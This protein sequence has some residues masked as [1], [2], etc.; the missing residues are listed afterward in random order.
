MALN[1]DEIAA[2]LMAM[3]EDQQRDIIKMAHAATADEFP[4]GWYPN[5]G[6]QT[7][8]YYCDADELFYGGEAGGGKT[9]LLLAT[10]LHAHT[11]SLIVRRLNGEVQGLIERMAEILGNRRGLKASSPAHWRVKH[12][13]IKFGG[14]QHD[15]DWEKY[16]G[17]PKDFL[18]FDEITH[19]SEHIFR[20]LIAWNRTVTKGQRSRVIATG[21]PPQSVE[22]MWVIKYWGPWLDKNHPD[23]AVPGEL[24]WYTTIN[25]QDVDVGGYRPDGGPRVRDNPGEIVLGDGTIHRDKNGRPI[26]PKSR[27]FIRAELA[28]N[29]DLAD[30]G[31]G[32][33]LMALPEGLRAG[34]GEGDFGAALKDDLW[35]V[36]PTEW[37]DAAMSRWSPGGGQTKG[38]MDAM[39]VDIAQGGEDKTVISRRHGGWYD[40][41]L[42]W[43]GKD[44]PDGPSVGA[45]V[46]LNRRDAAEVGL[47]MGGGYGGGTMTH[48]K[49][50]EVK[51]LTG[52]NGT[53]PGMGRDRT[54]ELKFANKRAADHWSL[55]D[56]LDPD[57]GARIAL[58]PDPELRADLAAIRFKHTATGI[59]VLSK[60]EIKKLIKRSP[61]RSDAVVI[62]HSL[63][64]KTFQDG[65][66][67]S[68]LPKRAN[69]SSRRPPRR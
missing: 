7:D 16:Q 26:L 33:R 24:R 34:L 1:L 57:Y 40:Q 56:D 54:G 43:P 28:D 48:L 38:K 10:A 20:T 41:L 4:Y 3:P 27:T 8:A 22:G 35:Q 61:D 55:R 59:Q 6:P 42:V 30:S 46:L 62:A 12:R 29:P 68:T 66:G 36:F 25:G 9:D 31:Y 5:P 51:P 60:E 21:N 50:N 14:C 17:D 32:D 18:G 47:D 58:P 53:F 63:R 65:H 64:A 39:G 19:F 13:L 23:P 15:A 44:T 49:D 37:I 67:N 52:Y 45:L 2:R 69:L 11:K